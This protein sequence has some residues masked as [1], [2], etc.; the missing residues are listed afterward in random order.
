[1]KK[2]PVAGRPA[3]AGSRGPAPRK[4]AA[5]RHTGRPG[6]GFDSLERLRKTYGSPAEGA[7]HAGKKGNDRSTAEKDG[8]G[9]GKERAARD[10]KEKNDRNVTGKGR[11]ER[12][13]KEKDGRNSMGKKETTRPEQERT[14][15][16][17]AGKASVTRAGKEQSGRGVT[18]KAA[19]RKDVA[20]K[21]P[22]QQEWPRK[23]SRKEDAWEREAGGKRKQE[24]E[25]ERPYKT[26]RQDSPQKR[27]ARGK[28]K[29]LREPYAGDKRHQ[30]KP[31]RQGRD[32]YEDDSAYH[33]P[34][35]EAEAGPMPLNKYI[36]HS[37]ICGRREAAALV[38]QG[39]AR[40]NG[41]LVLEPGYKIAPGDTVTLAGKKLIPQ[42]GLVYILLNKP[43]G[44]I[45]TTD[46]PQGRRTVMEL[47]SNAGAERI[48]PVGRLDRNTTGLLLITNDGMLAQKLAHPRHNVKKI[49]QVTL[50]KPLTKADFEQVRKG[51]ALE[52]GVAPVDALS[53]LSEPHELGI[54]IHSGRNRIVRRIFEALGYQVVKL[55]RVMY[56]GLTKKN[57]PRGKWRFLT[58]REVILLRHF[59]N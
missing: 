41:E 16:S 55:D 54:E 15:R 33:A 29:Q 11:T 46:D 52:D 56:A 20:G 26:T 35:K 43:K 17:A 27:D 37:G 57:I 31:G 30:Q 19:F 3:K 50:D 13:W 5:G 23:T 47:V 45:T 40:V 21:A 53:Y 39:K 12:P 4:S 34:A 28:G 36:A 8:A 51:V 22:G 25:Q 44:F 2:K 14:G 59:R 1:M 6:Q 49:Y 48:F 58:E 7:A 9:A 42:K 38:K 32:R 24:R 18:G 10:G